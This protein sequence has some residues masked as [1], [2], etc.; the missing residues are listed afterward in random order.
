MILEHR[1]VVQRHCP[2]LTKLQAEV[3]LY[4]I[5]TETHGLNIR[6]ANEVIH[7]ELHQIQNT[8]AVKVAG[9]TR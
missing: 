6:G 3:S 8:S 9:K 7:A 1:Y 2:K 4:R 5:W